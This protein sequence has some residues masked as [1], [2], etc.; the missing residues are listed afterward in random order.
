MFWRVLQV[1][2][3]S[4]GVLVGAAVIGDIY[5]LEERGQVLGNFFAVRESA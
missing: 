1:L 3:A 4:P 2:G 5:E